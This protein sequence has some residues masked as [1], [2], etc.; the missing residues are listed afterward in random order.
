MYSH[1]QDHPLGVEIITKL[2]PYLR[3]EA[4]KELELIKRVGD[5]SV[6]R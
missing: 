2:S 1:Q 5:V 4:L 6:Q 3:P